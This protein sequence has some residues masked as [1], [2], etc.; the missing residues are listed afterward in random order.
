MKEPTPAVQ[1]LWQARIVTELKKGTPAAETTAILSLMMANW[2]A[3]EDNAPE[4]TDPPNTKR[5]TV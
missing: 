2:Q 1:R 4:A 3:V 5:R